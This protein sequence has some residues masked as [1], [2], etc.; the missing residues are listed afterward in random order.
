MARTL[1]IGDVH[2]CSEEL[3][4]LVQLVQP[5]QVYLVGDL[6]TKGPDPLGVWELIQAF[7]MKSVLGNHDVAA[8]N[9][10][11][12]LGLPRAAHSWLFGLPLRI[13]G[14]GWTLVHAGIHPHGGLT[15][16]RM[17]TMMRHWTDGRF[18]FEHYSGQSMV[19]YGHDAR[20]GL[21]D[22]R[23]YTLG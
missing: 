1:F 23:P 10:P 5:T 16:Q 17:A 7:E 15:T 3:A 14:D 20:R 22:H 2:A 6:F 8:R 13:D 4:S 11:E 9:S 18:W 19:I 21:Q 12:L